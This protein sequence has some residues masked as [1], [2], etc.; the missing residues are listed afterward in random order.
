MENDGNRNAPP[1][2][3]V[4]L[5]L[6][7]RKPGK[8]VCHPVF[9]DELNKLGWL[10]RREDVSDWSEEEIVEEARQADV[11]LTDW[12]SITLPEKLAENPGRL[13]YI[14]NL[15]GTVRPYVPRKFIENGVWVSNW[16]DA[17]AQKVAEGALT[18]LLAS[19]KQVIPQNRE[20]CAGGWVPPGRDWIGSLDGLHLGVYGLGVIGSRFVEIVQPLKPVVSAFDPYVKTWPAGVERVDSL[21]T[22]FSKTEAVVVTAALNG[23]TRGSVRG[24]HLASLPEGGIVINVARGAI[25]DQK[26]LFRELESGRLRAGLDVLDS[27][28]KDFLEADHPARQ[29][30]NLILSTHRVSAS[31]WNE[32]LDEGKTLSRAQQIALDNIRRFAEGRPLL[33]AFDLTRFDRST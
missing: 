6:A 32:V 4:F 20:V 24:D 27:A 5:Y 8:H 13:R 11:I 7:K 16:G 31:T 2:R 14:C 22:L 26:A 33:H 15:A 1:H 3:L 9:T 30:S 21:E 19:L 12:G 17:P 28:G 10:Q 25:I 23:E 18:L 29:W